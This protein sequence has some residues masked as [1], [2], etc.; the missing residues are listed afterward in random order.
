VE[1][2]RLQLAEFRN[3]KTGGC[4]GD[5]RWSGLEHPRATTECVDGS[6]GASGEPARKRNRISGRDGFG[7]DSVLFASCFFSF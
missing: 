1:E 3:E 4:G 5:C 2:W 7:C 6:S